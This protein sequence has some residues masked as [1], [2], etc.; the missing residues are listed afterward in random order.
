MTDDRPVRIL[1][2]LDCGAVDRDAFNVLRFI[3]GGGDGG[4]VELT[5]LYIE[6]EDLYSAARLPGLPEVSATGAVTTLEPS[7]IDAEIASQARSARAEF[8]TSA[9]RS[10]LKYAFRVM[11]GRSVDTL[12]D[13]AAASDCVVVTRSLRASGLRARR[14]EHFEP[15]VAQKKNLL[16]VNEPWASG[17][18]VVVIGSITR[19]RGAGGYDVAS[20]IA[21]AEGLELISAAPPDER[22]EPPVVG[23]VV[24]LPEWSEDTIVDLCAREDARLLVLSAD[25]DLDWRA[26]LPR[27][28]DRLSCSLLRLS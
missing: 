21:D 6:D 13:A 25:A 27:L 28:I 12:V 22:V 2:T 19:Q 3:A 9:R 14:G 1:L 10:R 17:R 15:L 11:R 4:N 20:R 8:E 26:L 5:G 16:F 7:R 18:S 23:R 24:T